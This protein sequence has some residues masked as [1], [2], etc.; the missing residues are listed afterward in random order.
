M[1]QL[2]RITPFLWFDDNAEEAARFYTGVFKNSQITKHTR[3]GEAGKDSH[4]RPPGSTMTVE[5]ELDGQ[6]FAAL[7]GGPQKF[8]FSESV[9]F[10]INCQTQEEIDHYWDKLSEGGDPEAQQC[11]WL[12]DQYGLSW[13][14]VPEVL[15]ELFED[16]NGEAAGRT[17]E[18]MLKMKKLDIAGLKR[19]YAGET[20]S[21]PA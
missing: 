16:Y 12:K 13:Q 1:A 9:S 6:K 7:N 18:A 17:M 21:V 11:G 14:V 8:K 19:A 3:Y 2:Q 20:V 10:V 4:G 15:T 5:F